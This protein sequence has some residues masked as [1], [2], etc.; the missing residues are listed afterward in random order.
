MAA[1][2]LN[3]PV[4]IATSLKIIR[5]FVRMRELSALYQRLVSKIKE[6]ESKYDRQFAV[7]FTALD[8]LIE[9]ELNPIT[10]TGFSKDE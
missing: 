3:S 4:A 7:L 5:A 1:T 8:E 9:Y 6:M 2:V 10:V